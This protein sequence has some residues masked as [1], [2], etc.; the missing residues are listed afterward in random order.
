KLLEAKDP[1]HGP[2]CYILAVMLERKRILKVKE[3]LQREGRRVF[4]YEQPRTGD[5]FTITDPDLRLDQLE[6]VQRTT[7]ELLSPAPA[8]ASDPTTPPPPE[9]VPAESTG[10]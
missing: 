4:I 10:A 5:L 7:A 2:V 8:P 9:A 6:E 3:Q 1:K